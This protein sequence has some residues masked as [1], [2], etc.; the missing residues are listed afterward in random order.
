MDDHALQRLVVIIF[1][2]AVILAALG[3]ISVGHQPN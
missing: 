2:V 1:I 3:V